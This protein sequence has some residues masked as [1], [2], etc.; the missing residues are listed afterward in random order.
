L[1]GEDGMAGEHFESIS[2]NLPQED[3]AVLNKKYNMAFNVETEAV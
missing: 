2:L 1:Y 3:D